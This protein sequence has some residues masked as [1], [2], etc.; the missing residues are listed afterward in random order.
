MGRRVGRQRVPAPAWT[1]AHEPAAAPQ[2]RRAERVRD[3]S[4]D[5]LRAV[6]PQPHLRAG[7]A[8]VFDAR[9]P[10]GVRVAGGHLRRDGTGQTERQAVGGFLAVGA[11]RG[12]GV[13]AVDLSPHA[14]QQ[15]ERRCAER[16]ES[17][18]QH[19]GGGGCFNATVE[20]SVP[21]LGVWRWRDPLSG[22][23]W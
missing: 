1:V 2:P 12:R 14:Q 5:E 17:D 8:A 4:P 21:V 15:L 16:G 19:A 7:A 10:E 22:D 9:P 20:A 13:L 11:S 6:Q 18:A 3:R 23:E